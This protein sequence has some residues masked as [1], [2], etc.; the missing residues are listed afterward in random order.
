MLG[1]LKVRV[2]GLSNGTLKSDALIHG[3]RRHGP[4]NL[5][6]LQESK[7]VPVLV[8]LQESKTLPVLMTQ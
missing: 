8:N 5:V 4:E 2:A 7:T 3:R 6:I 1:F